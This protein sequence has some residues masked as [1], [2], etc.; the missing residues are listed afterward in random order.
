MAAYNGHN[1]R[2]SS[3]VPVQVP[4]HVT[5]LEP[6][7]KFSEVCE[8][9]V[10]NA[11][12]CALR[13]PVP[14]DEGSALHLHTQQ[15][16]QAKAHVVGCQ[17]I[18]SDG[19]A[20]LLGARL[21][22]PENLWGLE[23]FPDDWQLLQMATTALSKGRPKLGVT[24]VVV[25]KPQ[26]P[27]QASQAI[28][29]K[30]EEQLSDDRLRG[31]MARL[32]RPIETEISELQ[33]RLARHG[34]QNRFEVS[35]G[36][37]PPDLEEKL[38]QRLRQDLGPRVLEYTREQSSEVLAAA[39][40]TTEQK[41]TA[42][43]TEFRNRLSGELHTVELR[44]QE[45][46]KELI[47]STRQQ[48]SAGAERLQRQALDAGA[49]LNAHGEKLSTSLERRLLDM[50]NTHRREIEQ[51]HSAATERAFRLD[52]EVAGLEKRVGTLNESV[53]HLE[54]DLDAHLEHISGEIV[55]GARAQLASAVESAI[56]DFQ[57]RS[58][59]EIDSRV[60]E[61]CGQL[62]TIQNRI[63]NSFAGSLDTQ[64]EDAAKSLAQRFAELANQSMEK[65][66][67]ALAKD[68]NSVANALGRQLQKDLDTGIDNQVP[69]AR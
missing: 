40:V 61:V 67:T 36:Q 13:L 8:T 62:R 68:L 69:I 51:L 63:E 12:G 66:R 27:A 10:V 5:S 33:E 32:V 38:W 58:S 2:R 64:S 53:R 21:D 4:V 56:K 35:L 15:G 19:R 16:R 37:I 9:L 45:L 48:I 14:L 44:A 49:E 47:A 28:L 17:P 42:A 46:T 11:H 65:W 57:V 31:I 25:H 34:R 52:K 54:V 24:S 18:G 7:A 39:K 26:I 1:Q 6:N 30:I 50:L 55:S 43:L 29:H 60:D 59:N 20:W 41:T 22:Q 23:S 3:R